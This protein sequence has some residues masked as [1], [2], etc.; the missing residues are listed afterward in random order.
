[1]DTA[2]G[3]AVADRDA[4]QLA[5][6]LAAAGIAAAIVND[7]QDLLSDKQLT[8][9]NHWVSLD[10][11][12]MGPSIYDNIP[13]RLSRT[14]GRLRSPAPLLGADSRA[15]CVGLLG[16]PESEYDQLANEG[17]VG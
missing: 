14:P 13:Y 4:G 11:P 17:V 16:L 6:Q 9:R 5:D 15:V 3:A 7:A 1:I 10:H 12:E 8:Q 2:L